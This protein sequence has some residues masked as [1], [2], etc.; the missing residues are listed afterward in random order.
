V[1][2]PPRLLIVIQHHQREIFEFLRQSFKDDA[3]VTLIYERRVSERR[4]GGGAQRSDRRRTDRRQRRPTAWLYDGVILGVEQRDSSIPE[5]PA[6]PRDSTVSVAA[7]PECAA[8][9]EFELPRFPQPPARLESEVIHTQQ[10]E[11]LAQH[12]VEIHAFTASGRPLLS[13]R[14]HA[15]RPRR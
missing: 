13:H 5:S 6:P 7:C 12:Y 10:S 15:K 14:V 3:P 11:S 2:V 9:I 8:V 4:R 1:V